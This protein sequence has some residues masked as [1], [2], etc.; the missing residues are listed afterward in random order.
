MAT[1]RQDIADCHAA[2]QVMYGMRWNIE[3]L[4]REPEQTTGIEK[5]Q[6]R[7]A[8]IQRNH[9]AFAMLVW[10]RL[11][12]LPASRNKSSAVSSTVCSTTTSV[13]NSSIPPA[14]CE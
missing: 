8:R 9:I 5:N 1:F 12:T 7:K 2:V 14:G 4:H 6:C 10:L 13:S 3:Q 11:T